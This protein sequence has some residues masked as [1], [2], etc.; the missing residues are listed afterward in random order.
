MGVYSSINLLGSRFTVGCLIFILV[1]MHRFLTLNPGTLNLSSYDYKGF[2]R[3][4]QGLQ[5][6]GA[7]EAVSQ[8]VIITT[9]HAKAD[10]Y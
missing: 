8:R 7:L 10:G 3:F 4:F 9:K 1:Y 2:S 6:P 5:K